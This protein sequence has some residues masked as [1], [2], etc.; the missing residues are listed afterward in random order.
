[1]HYCAGVRKAGGGFQGRI[2]SGW[3]QAQKRWE[4]QRIFWERQRLESSIQV[5]D[6]AHCLPA[7]RRKLNA[8]CRHLWLQ[9]PSHSL[10]TLSCVRSV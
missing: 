6:T 1:M 7:P 4:A 5:P 9:R 10:P 2:A 8:G 3:Q